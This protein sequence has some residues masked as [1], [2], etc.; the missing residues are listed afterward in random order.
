MPVVD[1]AL[2]IACSV[3]DRGRTLLRHAEVSN[4]YA[5]QD[6][7]S[8]PA[9]AFSRLTSPSIR[10]IATCTVAVSSPQGSRTEC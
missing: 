2:T 4:E 6:L 10:V 9:H 1:V 8:E 3:L 5:A 7:S